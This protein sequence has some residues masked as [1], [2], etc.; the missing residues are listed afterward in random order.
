MLFINDD[1]MKF[2]TI[3]LVSLMLAWHFG[4]LKCNKMIFL[5]IL[6]GKTAFFRGLL[7]CVNKK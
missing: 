3:I 4:V 6:L 5:Q 7:S 1:D 2:L